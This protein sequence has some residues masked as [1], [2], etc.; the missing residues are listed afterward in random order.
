MKEHI[1]QN[2][3]DVSLLTNV[4]LKIQ[5]SSLK[6]FNYMDYVDLNLNFKNLE[7]NLICKDNIMEVY[8]FTKRSL[9]YYFQL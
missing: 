6:I 1:K 3:I 7:H 9:I 8:Y 2:T 4:K 5:K